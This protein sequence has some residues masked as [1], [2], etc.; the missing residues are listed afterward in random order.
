MATF[1]FVK[2]SGELQLLILGECDPVTAGKLLDLNPLLQGLYIRY[3]DRVFRAILSNVPEPAAALARVSLDFLTLADENFDA[4]PIMNFLRRYSLFEWCL[5]QPSPLDLVGDPLGVLSTMV[6]LFVEVDEA[7]RAIGECWAAGVETFLNPYMQ[8]EPAALSDTEHVRIACSLWVVQVYYQ[9][10]VQCAP[11]PP[12][13]SHDFSH[14]FLKG[15]EPWQ[16][17]QGRCI[18]RFVRAYCYEWTG[19]LHHIANVRPS[20]LQQLSGSK[21]LSRFRSMFE[22]NTAAQKFVPHFSRAAGN[23]QRSHNNIH[24]DSN[25][26]GNPACDSKISVITERLKNYAWTLYEVQVQESQTHLNPDYERQM[27]WN[28]GFLFWDA[29]R[30]I[31]THSQGSDSPVLANTLYAQFLHK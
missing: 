24:L 10:R 8:P 30:R 25:A 18:D 5:L 20:L 21:Y 31:S 7:A 4:I 16:V 1:P 17:E 2:L 23:V 26:L 14:A 15:L 6:D 22:E 29:E 19:S 12:E 13:I 9:M 11:Y 28:L 3:P 27:F